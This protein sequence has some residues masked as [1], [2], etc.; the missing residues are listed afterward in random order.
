MPVL[1]TAGHVD[2]GKTLLITALTGVDTDRL[3]EEKR[4]G[5]TIDLGF[6]HFLDSR[7]RPI[8]VIDVPGHE[9]YMRNMVAGA[10]GL[11][12]VLLVVAADDGWMPQTETHAWVLSV[13]G[14]KRII[15]VLNKIDLV[16]LDQVTAV[17]EDVRRRAEALFGRALPIVRVSART[18]EGID[19][20]KETIIREL[21]LTLERNQ[22]KI[23][24]REEEQA[25]GGM[26]ARNREPD[27]ILRAAKEPLHEPLYIDRVFSLKGTG[28]IVAGSLRR[29]RIRVNDELL[30]LPRKE[31]VRVRRIQS[32]HRDCQEVIA[33]ETTGAVR[34]ALNIHGLSSPPVRGDCLV[35]CS[36]EYYAGKGEGQLKALFEVQDEVLAAGYLL[37]SVRARQ[38][39]EI[40]FGTTHQKVTV[41]RLQRH[42]PLEGGSTRTSEEAS[43]EALRRPR[44]AVE[45]SEASK[46]SY[47]CEQHP[48]R[49]SRREG[50][51][52]G[53][54]AIHLQGKD[55]EPLRLVLEKAAFLQSGDRFLLMKPGG[56]DLLGWGEVLWVGKTT[57]KDRNRVVELF[58]EKGRSPTPGEVQGVLSGASILSGA[59]KGKLPGLKRATAREGGVGAEIPGSSRGQKA[60]NDGGS[61]TPEVLPP[62][63]L[64]LYQ[65]IIRQG[66]TPWELKPG[67]GPLVRE[68]IDR[69]CKGNR[70]VPLDGSFYMD[71][72]AYLSLVQRI[73][74][75]HAVGER[76]PIAEAKQA[77]GLSRKYI[78]P[79]LNRM[80][81]DGWVKRWGDDRVICRTWSRNPSGS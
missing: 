27:R 50:L 46:K 72:D 12:C 56:A 15:L 81:R 57:S 70:I 7:G 55:G 8:G 28:T 35:A 58:Q 33:D 6:T 79:L 25:R 47:G 73:L 62:R 49:A 52:A 32:Y 67:S 45:A 10:W 2:H 20:L 71:K 13:F 75:G 24:D 5:M 37:S 78:L 30:L 38:E 64:S 54:S 66:E 44:A 59:S 19:T 80:E 43:E 23:R 39:A 36:S 14:V 22:T 41:Y 42:R 1:G 51:R 18:G 76:F 60:G 68:D 17:E 21:E 61:G 53:E 48:Q 29:G 31:W 65:E 74:S 4:R 26:A 3:P 11:D 34:V 9:R 40:A 63:T 77:T 16:S 69:L